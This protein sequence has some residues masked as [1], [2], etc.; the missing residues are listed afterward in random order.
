[1]TTRKR[2]AR[3]D[4]RESDGFDALHN[5]FLS[6]LSRFEVL[7]EILGNCNNVPNEL[8]A[9]ARVFNDTTEDAVQLWDDA[10]VWYMAHEHTPKAE[11]MQS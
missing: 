6:L 1:V 7:S 2:T 10:E 3:A 8:A 4:E 11:A 5:R 9:A